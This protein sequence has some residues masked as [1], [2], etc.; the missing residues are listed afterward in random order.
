MTIKCLFTF[1]Y[2][3][4]THESFQKWI[5]QQ[6]EEEAITKWLSLTSVIVQTKTD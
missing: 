5:E 1:F 3:I 2:D 4:I 6:N